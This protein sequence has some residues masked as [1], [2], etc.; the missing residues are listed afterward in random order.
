M[1]YETC[2]NCT[3][4]RL[5]KGSLG[6]I[7]VALTNVIPFKC[8]S[9]QNITGKSIE[10]I[11]CNFSIFTFLGPKMS[12]SLKIQTATF[13]HSECLSSGKILDKS[14]EKI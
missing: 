2:Q 5:K 6:I 14:N 12:H 1:K 4:K 11:S 13:N 7:K 8:L 9:S 3:G 10:Y